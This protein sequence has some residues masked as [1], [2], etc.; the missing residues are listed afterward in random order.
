MSEETGHQNRS[1]VSGQ[2]VSDEEAATHPRTTVTEKVT[3][4]TTHIGQSVHYRSYGTPDGEYGAEC[5]AATITEVH[6][7]ATTV[8]GLAVLNP[9]GLFF[10]SLA[11]GGCHYSTGLE[12]GTWHRPE[13]G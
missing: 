10:R 11:D 13:N 9:T 12:G 7:D 3:R 5:R 4:P 6:P 1:S 2:Y 8:V